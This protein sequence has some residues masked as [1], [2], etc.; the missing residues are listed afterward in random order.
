MFLTCFSQSTSKISTAQGKP[1]LL[2]KNKSEDFDIP[3]WSLM[4]ILIMAERTKELSANYLSIPAGS[5]HFKQS[6]SQ[7]KERNGNG[8]LK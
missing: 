3:M 7:R 2:V 1:S 4:P 5:S 8:A 6:S